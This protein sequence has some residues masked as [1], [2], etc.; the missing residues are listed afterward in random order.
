MPGGAA[1]RY[2]RPA[3]WRRPAVALLVGLLALCAAGLADA[4]AGGDVNYRLLV[5]LGLLFLV[6]AMM[7]A[8]VARNR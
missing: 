3:T 1:N 8:A 6:A 5:T 4:V 2:S 7:S